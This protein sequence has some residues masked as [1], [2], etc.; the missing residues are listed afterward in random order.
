MSELTTL[1]NLEGYR[2][3]HTCAV[4]D[5][6]VA[7]RCF[8]CTGRLSLKELLLLEGEKKWRRK[9]A[10]IL[11]AVAP[12]FGHW[13]SGRRYIGTYFFAMA[14]LSVG[15]ILATYQKWSWGLSVLTLSFIIL[16]ILAIIDSR[17]GPFYF[18]A[19]CQEACPGSVAC[20]QYVHLAA[21]GKDKESLELVEAVCPFPGTIGRICHHPCEQS[22]NRGKDGDPV[23]ICA[24]KRFVERT[25][26]LWGRRSPWWDPGHRA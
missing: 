20:P 4:P 9:R 13:Y 7:R 2:E 12:G 11:S 25:T 16:W 18:R 14:P 22:C 23:A 19:P 3:C 10:P 6:M 8:H 24:L 1:E 26:C 15:L 21:A 17:K 5:K